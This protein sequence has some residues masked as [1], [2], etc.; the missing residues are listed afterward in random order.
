MKLTLGTLLLAGVMAGA[1]HSA[2]A[3][4][5]RGGDRGDRAQKWAERFDISAEQQA[6]L[7]QLRESNGPQMREKRTELRELRRANRGLDASSGDYVSTVQSLAEQ[8]ARIE[9]DLATLR[10]EHRHQI[11]GVLTAEQRQ[12]MAEARRQ[13]QEKRREAGK[14]RSG[15][16][17]G[18]ARGSEGSRR[19]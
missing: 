13:W 18:H 19:R 6:Q 1:S 3:S 5:S 15:K 12:A 7:Q 4:E 17:K 16:Y 14:H 2:I 11:A 9:V 10:A 8:R